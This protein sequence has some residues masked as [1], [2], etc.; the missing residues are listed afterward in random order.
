VVR[1]R[2]VNFENWLECITHH[3]Y[4]LRLQRI[5]RKI[6]LLFSSFSMM[7]YDMSLLFS[8]NLEDEKK[9]FSEELS[10]Y[11]EKQDKLIEEFNES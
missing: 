9:K 10:I 6:Y 2:R 1:I 4:T 7:T 8:S 3:V 5:I 11:R